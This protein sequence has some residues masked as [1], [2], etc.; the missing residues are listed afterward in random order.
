MS[1]PLFVV[2]SDIHF[3][4]NNLSLASK[5]LRAALKKAEDLNIPL[6]IAGDLQN[7]KD[8]IRGKVANELID[9]LKPAKIPVYIL[10]GNHD[11]LNEKGV[12]H[13]LNYLR[14]YATILDHSISLLFNK[15]AVLFVPYQSDKDAFRQKVTQ[16]RDGR[17]VVCHQGFLGAAM[18]DYIQD[19]S[20]IDPSLMK[21]FIV[22][23]GHY[24]RH[25]TIGTVTYIGS[26]YTITFGEANDGPKGFLIVNEDGSFT[27]EILNLRKH[28]VIECDVAD[29]T[30]ESQSLN[31]ND[32]IWLKIKGPQ[33]D[34]IKIDKSELGM[35]L[36]GHTNYKLDKIVTDSEKATIEVDKLT[37]AEIMDQLIDGVPDS[38][39]HK[40]KLKQLWRNL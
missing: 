23:S 3:S 33:S 10:E 30:H 2:I 1:K 6:V 35:R 40:V 4:L 32:L 18:G 26:P 9:I 31:K 7:D 20:S 5:A 13:G 39:E 8:I 24:H 22:I 12:E 17:I 27:R 36:F 38:E 16:E 14:P 28:V 29:L 11:K 34:L 15:I 25:Q 19:K 21:D 37:Y